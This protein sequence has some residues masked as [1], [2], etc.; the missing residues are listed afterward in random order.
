M[1]G[2]LRLA[3][4]LNSR[5]SRSAV[6]LGYHDILADSDGPPYTYAVGASRFRE[7]L[8]IARA[9]GFRFVHLE[10]LGRRLASGEDVAGL[11]CL[12]FDDALA[13][14]H[15]H[16]MPILAE[17]GLPW[18]LLPVTEH[19][20]VAP[21]WWPE[22]GPTMTRADVEEAISAGA[23]LAAHTANHVSLTDVAPDVA[24]REIRSSVETLSSWQGAPVRELCYPYGHHSAPVRQLAH[25]AGIRTAWTFTNGRARDGQHLFALPRL[26][27]HHG[28]SGARWAATLLRPS[29]TWPPVRDLSHAG[30]GNPAPLPAGSGAG[31]P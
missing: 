10:E 25:Q 21:H 18:T 24:E 22:A 7:Q 6:V 16:A 13:G 12:T 1:T 4:A 20:G 9:L 11:A 29:V 31:R 23:S 15:R 19:L 28:L 26:A 27:M 17:L 2:S 8:D 3:R 5:C 30:A 14:V